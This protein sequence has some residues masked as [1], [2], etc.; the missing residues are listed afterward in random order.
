MRAAPFAIIR[1]NLAWATVYNAVAI[2]AAALGLVSPLLAAVGMS[3]SSLVVV[4]NALRL[5]ARRRAA[6]LRR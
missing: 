2:P 4:G 1:E 6:A 3:C 5:S